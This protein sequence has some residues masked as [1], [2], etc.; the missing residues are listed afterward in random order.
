MTGEQLTSRPRSTTTRPTANRSLPGLVTLPFPAG[1]LI[2]A[3]LSDRFSAR[4][5]RTVLVIGCAMVAAGLIAMLLVL[6]A[7]GPDPAGWQIALPLAV[8]GLGNGLFIAPNIDFVLS[9]VPPREAGAASGVLNTGQ[10]SAR[11]SGSRR[12]A[13]SC[14]ARV[15]VTSVW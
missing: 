1:S 11:P 2:T 13:P 6:E 14:S 5:G 7:T 12:S 4:L 10:R 9:A 8:A 15:A 3:A